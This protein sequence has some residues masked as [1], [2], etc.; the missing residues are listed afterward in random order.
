MWSQKTTLS[1]TNYTAPVGPSLWIQQFLFQSE[2]FL[3]RGL[4]V[5]AGL[6]TEGLY[7]VSGNKTDQDNIQKQFDQ[8]NTNTH[9]C[10]ESHNLI[11]THSATWS[12]TGVFKVWSPPVLIIF[13]QIVIP[14]Y[15][16]TN[17]RE[18]RSFSGNML[19]IEEGLCGVCSK[20]NPQ[21]KLI[22]KSDHA[23]EVLKEKH[24]APRSRVEPAHEGWGAA[25]RAVGINKVTTGR[26][27]QLTVGSARQFT[28]S[29][30]NRGVPHW[31]LIVL[32]PLLL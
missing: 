7:R 29:W 3:S 15:F 5:F 16:P 28:A 18:L 32:F 12:V 4:F 26:N 1:E 13:L 21:R 25:R 17:V 11:N 20:F 27:Q 23:A 2:L 6:T 19:P 31:L 8:G 30:W 10:T 14:N 9:T 22:P 24:M